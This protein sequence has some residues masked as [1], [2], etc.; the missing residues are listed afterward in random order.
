M[1][2]LSYCRMSASLV[3]KSLYWC[4][5]NICP[6]DQ[7]IFGMA[8]MGVGWELYFTKFNTSRWFSFFLSLCISLSSYEGIY[9]WLFLSFSTYIL[10][11]TISAL[12]L[13]LS[14]S[15][16]AL[17]HPSVHS[18]VCP[19]VCKVFTFSFSSPEP[20]II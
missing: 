17:A 19:F 10:A 20:Q 13:I 16:S 2:Q 12:T 7:I 15:L 1:L 4:R 3:T 14:F 9:F 5:R 11:L 6:C 8:I 18:S